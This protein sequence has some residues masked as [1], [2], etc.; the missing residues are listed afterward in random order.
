MARTGNPGRLRHLASCGHEIGNHSLDHPYHLTTLPK[1]ELRRQIAVGREVLQGATG[2]PIHGFRAPGYTVHD[3]LLAEVAASGHRYDSSIFPCTPY[4]LAKFSVLSWMQL[5]GR[6]SASIR[7]DLRASLAPISP[8]RIGF[9]Y[10]THGHAEALLELP[11]QV[12]PRLR[13]P[14]IG[15]SLILAP[16]SIAWG[17]LRSCIGLPWIHIE[18]HGMDLLGPEDGLDAL[19]PFQPDARISAAKKLARLTSLFETLREVG[20]RFTTLEDAAR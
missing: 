18:L 9:P 2:A 1:Q 6:K 8:Y 5:R 16:E 10:W 19:R 15:T 13:L 12:T 17:L 7:G 14:V 4:L 20:Y 3:A 11:I